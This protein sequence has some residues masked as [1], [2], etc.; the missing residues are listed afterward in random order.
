[1]L[2]K[3]SATSWSRHEPY[4]L[5]LSNRKDFVMEADNARSRSFGEEIEFPPLESVL[6]PSVTEEDLS[7]FTLPVVTKPREEDIDIDVNQGEEEEEDDDDDNTPRRYMFVL[8]RPDGD[9]EENNEDENNEEE[10]D[11]GEDMD[12]EIIAHGRLN[13]DELHVVEEEVDAAEIAAAEAL[14]LETSQVEELVKMRLRQL[15]REYVS[16]GITSGSMSSSASEPSIGASLSGVKSLASVRPD[17]AARRPE[18]AAKIE[19]LQKLKAEMFKTSDY[20]RGDKFEVTKGNE[21]LSAL[22][23]GAE[24]DVPKESGREHLN[25]GGVDGR[26]VVWE[27]FD[28][29]PENY[30]ELQLKDSEAIRLAKEDAERK[31]TISKL[32]NVVNSPSSSKTPSS[33]IPGVRPVSPLKSDKRDAIKSVMAR[34]NISPRASPMA[35]ALAQQALERGRR[36]LAAFKQTTEKI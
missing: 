28:D 21:S 5:I 8:Q 7:V 9:T 25:L 35:E 24:G 31:A 22:S 23:S 16:T 13:D 4:E 26:G 12:K 17:L 3:A 27:T 34:I 14:S 30:G 29:F 19:A 20:I 36:S 1:V 11:D 18:L 33:L 6:T 15:D 32:E 10:D 2:K